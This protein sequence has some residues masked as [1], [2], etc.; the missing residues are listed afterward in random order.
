MSSCLG[1]SRLSG[2]VE[3]IRIVNRLGHGCSYT[4][5]EEIDTAL[6]IEKMSS[7]DEGA[8]LLPLG[9][10]PLIPTVLAYDNIDALEET[11]SGAG[12]SHRVNG[13]IVQPAVSTCATERFTTP[14]LSKHDKRRTVEANVDPLPLYISANRESPP[15][16]KSPNL[17]LP[18]ED[19]TRSAC[20]RNLLWIL[21]R[22]HETSRQTTSSWTGFNIQ[23]RGQVEVSADK[24]GYLPTINAPVTD[25]STAQEILCNALST[26]ETLSLKN[27]A[28][29]AD[30]ALY[31]KLTE[32]VWNNQSKFETIIPMMGNFHI[33]CNLLSIIGKVFRDAEL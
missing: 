9:T 23:T 14:A 26:Q 20:Q 21:V 24:V 1:S 12:T 3:L 8:P 18:F 6:C 32:V 7:V 28:V 31:A 10:H 19:A 29:V 5:L 4:R 25:I 16:L 22:L 33:I 17:L 11:L 2:N 27:I 15:P 13:I 30:Q